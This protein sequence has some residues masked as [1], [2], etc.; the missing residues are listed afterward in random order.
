M[1]SDRASLLGA[2]RN[3]ATYTVKILANSTKRAAELLLFT[4]G[5]NRIDHFFIG[6]NEE[7]KLMGLQASIFPLKLL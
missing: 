7:L 4:L 3:S 5:T 1:M 2:W 6:T